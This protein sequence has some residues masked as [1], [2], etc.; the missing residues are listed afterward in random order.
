MRKLLENPTFKAAFLQRYSVHLQLSFNPTRSLALMDSVAG[1][2][3]DEVPDH[4]RRWSKSMRLGN[5]M[6]WE[7]HLD[8][9][10]DFLSQRP[11]K[12]REHIKE[13]SEQNVYIA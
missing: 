7:K 3:A 6:N 8:V 13:F 10:R 9:M 1:L 4:M 2:I 11:D 5:D 12:E